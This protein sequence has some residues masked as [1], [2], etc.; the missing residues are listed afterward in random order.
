MI[1]PYE[2]F[3]EA[4]DNEETYN[5]NKVKHIMFSTPGENLCIVL[6]SICRD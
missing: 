2:K 6:I 5:R 4:I 3:L 1:D